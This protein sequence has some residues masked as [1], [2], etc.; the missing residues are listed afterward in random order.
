MLMLTGRV[1]HTPAFGHPSPR[2]E[3]AAARGEIIKTKT[4]LNV[5]VDWLDTLLSQPEGG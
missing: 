2:G 1:R 5:D 3:G 4:F